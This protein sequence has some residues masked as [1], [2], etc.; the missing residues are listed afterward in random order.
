[1]SFRFDG[2]LDMRMEQE[3][4]CA[5]DIVNTA[6]E[7]DLSTI[8]RRFGEERHARRVARAIVRAR[9]EAPI[10]TTGALAE[11]V[12][13]AIPR[14]RPDRNRPDRNRI[15]PATRT[16]QALR[17]ATND[18]LDEIDRGLAAAEA[19]LA[20]G[21]ILVVVSFHSLEDKRVKDFLKTRSGG[22]PRPSR[23]L[24]AGDA[25]AAAPTFDLLTRRPDRPGEDEVARNPRARSARLRA[26][27]RTKAPTWT[28]AAMAAGGGA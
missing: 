16:F 12:R 22:A 25:G 26:G 15:D 24:P 1:F 9:A 7:H 4:P 27:R 18:E 6:S 17:I 19:L 28:H 20:P 23:Y 3:G 11:I 13:A 14:G 10:E 8:I 5:A 21:G 2:P